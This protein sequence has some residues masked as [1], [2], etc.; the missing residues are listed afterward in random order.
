MCLSSG[1]N[2]YL[3]FDQGGVP[4]IR[5]SPAA[6]VSVFDPSQSNTWQLTCTGT[7]E[8]C[9][10]ICVI[11]SSTQTTLCVSPPV[12]AHTGSLIPSAVC[13]TTHTHSVHSAM[14]VS[15][16]PFLFPHGTLTGVCIICTLYVYLTAC[17]V[18]GALALCTLT[19][20]IIIIF[21]ALMDTCICL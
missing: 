12:C 7:G 13:A 14:S 6:G 8:C 5:L 10:A 16:S 18:V 19:T 9:S 15:A 17:A 1:H 2:H 4:S 3:P 11:T 20:L 21:V